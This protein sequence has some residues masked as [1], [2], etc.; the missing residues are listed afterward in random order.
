MSKNIRFIPIVLI[1]F[2]KGL[3]ALEISRDSFQKDLKTCLEEVIA[4]FTQSAFL[5]D[6]I[7]N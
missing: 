5:I 6:G 3:F 4:N 1:P 7:K 2:L